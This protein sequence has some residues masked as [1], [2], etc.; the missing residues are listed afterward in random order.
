LSA[1]LRKSELSNNFS[2]SH[3]TTLS[4][5]DE[6]LLNS[7]FDLILLDL[8]LPDAHG[9]EGLSFLLENFP[10]NPVVVLT[11]NTDD[12]VAL[13]AIQHGAQDYLVKQDLRPDI[14]VKTCNYAIERKKINVKLKEAFQREE[15]LNDE[16]RDKNIEL[17]IAFEALKEEK[18]H[19][20]EK[21]QQINSFISM[22][23]NDLKNPISAI[24]SLLGLISEK[25]LTEKQHKYISQIQRSSDSML[26]NILRIIDTQYAADGVV[27]VNLQAENP[28][29][30]INSALDKYIVEA[31]RRN[32][33]VEITYKNN[34]PDTLIDKSTLN[35]VISSIFEAIFKMNDSASRIII[36]T[37]QDGEY[38]VLKFLD[39][40]LT[41]TDKQI[42]QLLTAS[43][44]I[45]LGSTSIVSNHS[46]E[47]GL[48]KQ[49]VQMMGG[50]FN[51]KK[52]ERGKGTLFALSLR[53]AETVHASK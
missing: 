42:N 3:V 39:K 33:I 13:K 23:V 25:P 27:K 45:D 26:E 4:Q 11:G 22:L 50:D 36:G 19:V 40:L 17:N 15:D 12:T 2:I 21:N 10:G 9:L 48:V 24:A 18:K 14:L 35:S 31:I 34:L 49:L 47:L 20:E 29:F 43:D 32:I 53:V 38:L 16:L 52:S 46:I 30:T 6:A 7:D 1:R 44:T 51:I 28:Y 41:L 37:E 8:S 5:A